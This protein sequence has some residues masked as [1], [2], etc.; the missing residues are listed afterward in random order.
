MVGATGNGTAAVFAPELFRRL[1]VGV[2]ESY[3]K[4][5]YTFPH[6][7]RNPEDMEMLYEMSE[8]I[9]ALGADFALEFDCDG[10]RYSVVE[11]KGEGIYADKVRCDLS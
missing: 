5:G 4:L 11:G 1:G 2:V 7:N 8:S 9:K 3:N 10:D 6:Y